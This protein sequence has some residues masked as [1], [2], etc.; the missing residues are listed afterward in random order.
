[1]TAARAMDLA[2]SRT[3]EI[4]LG[5]EGW[6]SVMILILFTGAVAGLLDAQFTET[7]R[8]AS[9]SP[10][11]KL[12]LSATYF[13]I[14]FV[15]YR[16]SA[17][18]PRGRRTDFVLT[19]LLG[20]TFASIAWSA[21][22]GR[23]F[24]RAIQ[25]LFTT[26]FG[27]YIGRRYSIE[28]QVLLLGYALIILET[29]SIATSLLLPGFGVMHGEFEGAWRGVFGHKNSLGRVAFLGCLVFAIT[30]PMGGHRVL[31]WCG[32][33]MSATLLV[34]ST[35]RSAVVGVLVVGVLLPLYKTLRRRGIVFMLY[36]VA[37]VVVPAVAAVWAYTHL[38]HVLT[39][40]G[41]NLT[42]SGRTS[43]WFAVA[44]FIARRPLLGYGYNA[45]W[46]GM[47][48]DSGFISM[49]LRWEV[50]HAHNG[51]LELAL[52]TG[53]LGVVLFVCSFARTFRDAV[54]LQKLGDGSA[55]M[56]PLLGLTFIAITNVTESSLLRSNNTFWLIYLF[57]AFG[58]RAA[59]PQAEEDGA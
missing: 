35:S 56:W 45:F 14:A 10:V 20:V 11:F 1:M 12:L 48:G 15:T 8:G 13:F 51:L 43:L 46:Q 29:L 52:D 4:S 40:L 37:A 55:A 30:I 26:W 19:L 27:A 32:A 50:P 25:L 28:R 9:G 18:V 49:A 42:L 5:G 33:I 31:G 47:N 58:T 34:L 38:E 39:L 41:R 53:L 21:L 59:I 17:F 3:T 6:I 23:S 54:R 57:L 36:V 2:A 44:S 24:T 16:D 22:P 7:G